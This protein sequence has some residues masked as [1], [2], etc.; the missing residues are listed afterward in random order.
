M[1][2]ISS[3]SHGKFLTCNTVQIDSHLESNESDINQ[4]SPGH[5]FLNHREDAKQDLDSC[6]SFVEDTLS[7]GEE[8]DNGIED[9]KNQYKLN[10]IATDNIL[11]SNNC[12]TT[13][14]RTFL[15]SNQTRL[16]LRRGES[17]VERLRDREN[18]ESASGKEMALHYLKRNNNSL[19]PF[20]RMN[21]MVTNANSSEDFKKELISCL[22]V[23][24]YFKKKA[25]TKAMIKRSQSL[26]KAMIKSSISE[27]KQHL[28][29]VK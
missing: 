5:H 9:D 18:L 26:P 14:A 4:I 17:V 11:S 6:S 10:V 27:G 28:V 22:N 16:P 3:V 29:W 19:S 21:S 8:S 13:K 7:N 2:S 24:E 15:S 23:P 20:F 1:K 25:R 12:K